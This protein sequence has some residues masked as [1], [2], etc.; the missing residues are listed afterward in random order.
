MDKE[1]V[2]V[3]RIYKDGDRFIATDSET[4]SEGCGKSYPDALVDL[5][6][7]MGKVGTG[8]LQIMED[9]A[10]DEIENRNI[11]IKCSCCGGE[12]DFDGLHLYIE[13]QEDE[14]YQICNRC[15]SDI[16]CILQY[17]EP[18]GKKR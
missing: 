12:T 13:T 5:A 4:N 9:W 2:C 17:Y 15:C 6:A 10:R 7:E 18:I 3:V 1:A 11:K 16:C 8:C 14:T